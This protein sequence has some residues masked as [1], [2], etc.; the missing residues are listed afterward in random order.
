[1]KK[2]SNSNELENP[3]LWELKTMNEKQVRNLVRAVLHVHGLIF[4][5]N[6]HGEMIHNCFSPVPN[7]EST[8]G[9]EKE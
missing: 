3:F 4:Q 5:E 1:M 8:N 6:I 2:W 9:D 7:K